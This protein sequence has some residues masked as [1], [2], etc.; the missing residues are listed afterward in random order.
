MTFR[1]AVGVGSAGL[2]LLVASGCHRGGS[3]PDDGGAGDHPAL[4]TCTT[5]ATIYVLTL[6]GARELLTDGGQLGIILG[7]QGFQFARVG[8]VTG[9]ELPPL[10]T[11]E[12]SVLVPGKVNK[13]VRSTNV[14]TKAGAGGWTTDVVNLFFND[15]PLADL[16]GKDGT[17]VLRATGTSCIAAAEVHVVLVAGGF[18]GADGGTDEADAEPPDVEPPSDGG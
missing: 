8:V 11:V 9:D 17:L 1:A 5:G 10:T 3:T 13:L 12:S 18:Q 14:V 15:V 2:A 7:F 4:P 6:E 16:I